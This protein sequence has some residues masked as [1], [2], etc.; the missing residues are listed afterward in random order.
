[1]HRNQG[2][3]RVVLPLLACC[4]GW[5][6]F[7]ELAAQPAET[8]AKRFFKQGLSAE[9][10]TDRIR[11][12]RQAVESDPDFQPARYQLGIAL[13]QKGEF[14]EAIQFLSRLDTT[15]FEDTH[16]YLRNA[17]TFYATE[18][19]EHEEFDRALAF[20]RKALEL[21][22]VY[23]PALR[24][25]GKSYCAR[26]IW[27]PCLEALSESVT[28]DT[29]Q[30]LVWNQLGDLH[31]RENEYQKAIDAYERALAL[32]SDLKDAR[33]HLKIAK[34][35]QTPELYLS[36]YAD[37]I[38]RGDFDGG[39]SILRQARELFPDNADIA[40]K[41]QVSIQARDYLAALEAIHKKD[42][43]RAFDLLRSI[44]PEYR[45]TALRL[46]EVRAELLLNTND[47]LLSSTPPESLPRDEIDVADTTATFSGLTESRDDSMS[48]QTLASATV[49]SPD[50]AKADYTERDTPQTIFADKQAVLSQSD[51]LPAKKTQTE[52]FSFPWMWGSL[53][54]V[55]I[56]AALLFLRVKKKNEKRAAT[57]SNLQPTNEFIQESLASVTPV[58]FDPVDTEQLL[59]NGEQ[60]SL[61]ET[62]TLSGGTKKVQRIG[63]YFIEREIG[64]G[65]M[66]LVY[67]AWDPML[68]RVV[69]IKQ[70]AFDRHARAAEVK[71]LR[72]RLYREARAAGKLNHPNSDHL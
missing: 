56:L 49:A 46:E 6:A 34:Q 72:D 68:D 58:K 14:A 23:P 2:I 22:P 59:K 45:D 9:S 7:G 29:N 26:Q 8:D 70:M 63:R 66:G 25:L 54:G 44:D 52:G 61:L 19:N 39:I 28:L 5:I 21:D 64:K 35:R 51:L 71:R 10:L 18:L 36:K 55:M 30:E 53:A 17:Y 1:M 4:I 32:N 27:E 24:E 20:A 33:F 11:H 62:Q 40:E 31:L 12:F 42:W 43:E 41:L 38:Q 57:A 67:K 13:Y 69:V 48:E 16:L 37:A 47:S 65:A 3:L 15:A 60:E 50:T